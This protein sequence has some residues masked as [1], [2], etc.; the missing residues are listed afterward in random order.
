MKTKNIT[1]VYRNLDLEL[2]AGE[3]EYITQHREGGIT[4]KMD[5]S[6]VISKIII[7]LFF[8]RFLIF[9]KFQVY[10]NS[11][12]GHEHERIIQKFDRD[13]LGKL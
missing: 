9:Y 5:Y 11:R 12:L 13:S 7:P 1:N 10:W 8:F 3:K 4:Y 6:T 2:L